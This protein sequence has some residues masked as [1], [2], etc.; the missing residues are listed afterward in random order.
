MTYVKFRFGNVKLHVEGNVKLH[1]EGNVKLHVEGN[2][3][4]HVEGAFSPWS[5]RR[6]ILDKTIACAGSISSHGSL[7]HLIDP[8]CL[9]LRTMNREGGGRWPQ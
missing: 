3:K 6:L 9:K 2:V 7:P 4:L 1:V 8:I 5:S